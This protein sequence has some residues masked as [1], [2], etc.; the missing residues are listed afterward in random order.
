MKT[1]RFLIFGL[2][3]FAGVSLA[4]QKKQLTD[5]ELRNNSVRITNP[6]L[7]VKEWRGNRVTLHCPA[8]SGQG[9]RTVVVDA[10][11]GKIISATE[12]PEAQAVSSSGGELFIG[13]IEGAVNPVMSPDSAYVAF[14]R[15]NDL[16]TVR[17]AD[18]KETR[19]T[20]DGSDDILNGYASWV[21][22]EEILGRAG[23]YRAFWWSPDSRRLAFFRTDDSRVPLFTITDSPGKNGYVETM[24]YPKAGDALPQVKAGVVSPDG[25]EITWA[26]IDS[27][28]EHYL[29][30]PY[31]RPDGQALWLQWL[32][33]AQNH[34]RLLEIA[35]GSGAV[36]MLYEERQK[37][38]ISLDDE[39]R[40]HFL[41]S[42]KG[43]ILVSDKSGWRQLYLHD[44][45]GRLQRRLTAGS[46]TVT[47]IPAIDERTKT[48]Y[49]TACNG[50][51]GALD[52]YRV[53]LDGKRLQRL[54][55]GNYSHR[56]VLS[57]DCRY[58]VTTYSNVETPPQVALYRTNGQFVCSIQDSGNEN[59]NLYA[60][61]ETRFITLRSDDGRFVIPLRI[62]Y[63]LSM[64]AGKKYPVKLNI[65]GG[66]GVMQ[67]RNEWSDPLHSDTYRYARDGLL[68]VT[69][70]HRGS[71]HNGK[72][73]QEDL[74]RRLGYWEITDYSQ[75][76]RWLTE[77]AQ[78]DAGKIMITGFSYGGY[79]TCYA[80][81]YGAEVFT[82]GIAGG[83]VTDWQLYDAAYTERYMGA[84]A[85]NPEGY[86]AAS[87]LTHAARLKGKLLLTHGL[88]DENVHVQNTFQLISVWENLNKDFELM[89]YPESRHGYRHAKQEHSRRLER[90]FVYTY[91]LKK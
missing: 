52:F 19:L 57:P 79:L 66:P 26:L 77:N 18:R 10:A 38:W 42:G 85:D 55:F 17:L 11:A 75:A 48:V 71:G 56:I 30:L 27:S 2:F 90:E 74:F 47:D 60:Y 64:E 33:R 73:G 35:P 63:P 28:A 23:R 20:F 14:T 46:Y 9:S 12:G 34:Y 80:L 45:N 7:Q 1:I 29:G 81:T 70:D 76:V 78:A 54:S 3:L 84:P 83:S 72:A 68:Q 87:A 5:E 36:K 89:I 44:M 49:F 65:Y 59:C 25:G 62:T 40:I 53:G 39:P 86:A 31:W 22:M 41:P 32:N 69:L 91:L 37:T 4:A 61:P 51:P 8:S 21:Y 6:V 50:Q 15:R 82:H 16:Y 67:A 24:R 88:R 58:F 43:F 13:S